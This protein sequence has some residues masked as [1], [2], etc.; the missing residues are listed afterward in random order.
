MSGPL[1]VPGGFI[2]NV[3][4]NVTGNVAGNVTG[5]VTSGGLTTQ[6]VSELLPIVADTDSHDTTLVI[7]INAIIKRVWLSVT[8][9]E[10]TGTTKTLIVGI[11]GGDEDGFLA[12]VSVASIATVKGTLLNTG[13]TLGALMSVDEDGA[14]AL[15]PEPYITTAATT[16][17]YTLVAADYA[18]MVA[19]V[20]VEYATLA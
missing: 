19:K 4:G 7:P 20:Y 9:A 16:I 15:S 1:T 13:Q 6:T 18:E 11:S 14:G 8:T 10:A 2:G 5:S 17:A 12:G 3:T